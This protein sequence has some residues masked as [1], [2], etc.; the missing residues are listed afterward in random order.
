MARIEVFLLANGYCLNAKL[1]TG[2]RLENRERKHSTGELQWGISMAGKF[3]FPSHNHCVAKRRF[4]RR[5]CR[6]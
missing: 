5:L 4:Y 3:Y 6:Y 2:V 1:K